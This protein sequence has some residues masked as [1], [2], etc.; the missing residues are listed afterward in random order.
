M[1]NNYYQLSGVSGA[2]YPAYSQPDPLE[3]E[4][5]TS[6]DEAMKKGFDALKKMSINELRA[7]NENP[8]RLSSFLKESFVAQPMVATMINCREKVKNEADANLKFGPD[9]DEARQNVQQKYEELQE[10][11][12]SY[13]DGN[14]VY[15]QL[16]QKFN[17][18]NIAQG[19]LDSVG[20]IDEESEKIAETFLSGEKDLDGFLD[21]YIRHRTLSHA[22]KTK[23]EKL[24]NQLEKLH[25][26]NY[27]QS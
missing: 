25:Q 4:L 9:L 5:I 1:D 20:K 7:L 18:Q 26:A 16:C 22:Q 12:S 23:H 11:Q 13:K 21:E 6:Y 14:K 15:L 24:T 8:D 2:Q 19:L 17:P 27:F 10:L 3:R